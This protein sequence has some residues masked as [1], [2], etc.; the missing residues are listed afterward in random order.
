MMHSVDQIPP[1]RA[2]LWIF[3][4][5]LVISGIAW[6]GWL[7]YLHLKTASQN[8]KQYD[9]IAIMQ[10]SHHQ[11]GLKTVYLAELLGLSV[12]KPTNLY[13]F[14]LEE[15]IHRLLSSPLIKEGTIKKIRPGTLYIDYRMRTPIAYL[16]DYSN[17]AIDEEG[18]LFPFSPFFTPKRLPLIYI[19]LDS[20]DTKWGQSIGDHPGFQKAL[21]VMKAVQRIWGK[22]LTLLKQID[23]SQAFA[24]SFGQR[25]IVLFVDDYFED[26]VGKKEKSIV[27]SFY[28]RLNPKD[29]LQ[30]LAN[31][32]VLRDYIKEQLIN[33][34]SSEGAKEALKIIPKPG[35]IDLRIAHLGLVKK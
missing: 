24:E 3:I 9:I 8:D 22:Q 16:G 2:F 29:Y 21:D 35:I 13:Q 34:E 33:A 23:V 12:D 11:E 20:Q 28:L 18:Y 26:I 6:M 30:N 5:T 7:Y 19:G 10:S 32:V 15:G 27:K 25:Q 1:S 14:N 4:W 31:Y 17:T